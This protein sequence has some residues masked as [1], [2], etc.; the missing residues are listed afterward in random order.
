LKELRDKMSRFNRL[1]PLVE[2]H[3]LPPAKAGGLNREP[4]FISTIVVLI[5]DIVFY[6]LI[7]DISTCAAEIASSPQMSSPVLFL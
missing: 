3:K 4:I 5:L 1:K 6:D 7:G 2:E